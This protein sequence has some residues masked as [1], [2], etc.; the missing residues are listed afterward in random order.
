[1]TSTTRP[2][3]LSGYPSLAVPV[4]PASDG[5]GIAMQLIGRPFDEATLFR[6]GTAYERAAG[7]TGQRP[8][9]FPATIPAA[10]DG[11][12]IAPDPNASL[13]PEWVMD[14]ARLLH[15]DFV[16]EEDAVLIAPMLARVKDQLAEA[17]ANLKLD[18]EIPTRPAGRP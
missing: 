4:A 1:M 3:S 16:I 6:T 7:Y 5:T 12:R 11:A 8:P 15:Y 14:M 2:S 18:L 9:S 13:S 10:S 17:Q